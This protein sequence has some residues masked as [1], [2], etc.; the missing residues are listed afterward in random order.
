MIVLK[1]EIPTRVIGG[2]WLLSY[3]SFGFLV[4]VFAYVFYSVSFGC[5]GGGSKIP[6]NLPTLPFL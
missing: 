5:R 2:L 1:A 3:F 6:P 4:S